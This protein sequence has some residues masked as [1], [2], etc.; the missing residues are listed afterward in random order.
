MKTAIF[1]TT[2][3]PILIKFIKYDRYDKH[4][5]LY[6]DDESKKTIGIILMFY[7]LLLTFFTIINIRRKISLLK[8]YFFTNIINFT[9]S[10]FYV[11]YKKNLS[12]IDISC[13]FMIVL[14]IMWLF[15]EN[16]K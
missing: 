1:F 8:I 15:I 10:I 2:I 3:F 6:I 14:N 9:L 4:Y 7:S 13:I 16:D 5:T 12:T 11:I